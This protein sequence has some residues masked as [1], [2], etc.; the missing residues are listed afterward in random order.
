MNDYRKLLVI[1]PEMAIWRKII[2]YLDDD[3][4]NIFLSTFPVLRLFS[5]LYLIH[6]PKLTWIGKLSLE[7]YFLAVEGP[8]GGELYSQEEIN[9]YTIKHKNTIFSHNILSGINFIL[10]GANLYLYDQLGVNHGD[11]LEKITY[12]PDGHEC[13]LDQFRLLTVLKKY[14]NITINMLYYNIE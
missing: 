11:I 5:D 13:H 3:T 9:V 12:G 7:N 4:L 14:K 6:K 2:K 8:T 10:K 1:F